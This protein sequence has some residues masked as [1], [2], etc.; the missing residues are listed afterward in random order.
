L[1][2]KQIDFYKKCINC[3]G[4]NKEYQIIII[5]GKTVNIKEF[6]DLPDNAYIYNY[7]PQTQVL[8]NA[9]IFITHEGTN[10]V[11]EA[12]ILKNLPLIVFPIME[13]YKKK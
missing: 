2:I 4:N 10:S 11:Y 3:F 1:F 6:G 9:D 12:L 5:V 7:V 8:D 13:D